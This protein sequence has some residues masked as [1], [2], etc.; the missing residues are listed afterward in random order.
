MYVKSVEENTSYLKLTRRE[1]T[2]SINKTWILLNKIIVKS[3][4]NPLEF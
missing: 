4:E 2:M 3:K 1:T